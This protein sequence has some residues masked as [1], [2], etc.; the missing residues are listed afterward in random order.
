MTTSAGASRAPEDD[1]PGY[2]AGARKTRP[3]IRRGGTAAGGAS[4]RGTPPRGCASTRWRRPPG[5]APLAVGSSPRAHLRACASSSVP[6]AE[7][8][9]GAISSS[10]PASRWPVGTDRP[11]RRSTISPLTPWRAADQRFSAIRGSGRAP[12]S[13]LSYRARSHSTRPAAVVA[14]A[15][16]SGLRSARRGHAPR[17]SPAPGEAAAPTTIRVRWTR[18]PRAAATQGTP[19]HAASSRTPADPLPRQHAADRR[20]HRRHPLSRPV[21]RRVRAERGEVREVARI[22][23]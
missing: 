23:L 9:N 6:P 10:R 14:T 12:S 1:L 4:P 13:S 8:A 15:A 21:D 7:P 19:R 22:A 2:P 18:G 16:A 5:T 20:A 11:V 17:S 3:S